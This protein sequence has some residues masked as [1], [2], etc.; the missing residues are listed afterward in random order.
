MEAFSLVEKY[1]G[2]KLEGSYTGKA[3]AALMDDAKQSNLKDKVIL[4]EEQGD[5]Y[6]SEIMEKMRGVSWS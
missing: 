4:F 3:F 6:G 5:N 1:A 2:I